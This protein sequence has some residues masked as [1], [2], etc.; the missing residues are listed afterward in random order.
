MSLPNSEG[1]P[2]PEV[3]FRIRED[4]EWKTVT[5]KEIFASKTVVV[6]SLPGAFTPTCSS[7]HLPRYNELAPAFFANGVDEIV[8]VSVNDTFVMNEWAKDQESQ[9]VRLI[10]DGNGEFT[11]QIGM[12]VDKSDLGFGKR[13]WRYSMLVKDGI[14]VKQFIEPEKEGD[15]FEVSDADTM[16]DFINPQAKKPDQVAIF[17]R[18]GCGFCARAKAKLT[19]LGYEYVEI[20]LTHQIRSKVIG[21]VTGQ[22]TV[23][24]VFINGQHI[25]D[26]E[27][28]DQWARKAA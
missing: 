14:I 9:N 3:S 7:T 8:C 2:I 25:G 27:T 17:T 23:P 13:S 6:F 20:P 11:E 5:S 24:Q 21:A 22:Q 12:L 15:P 28:L 16:L 10:P 4:D 26:A 1:R 18:E 19:E